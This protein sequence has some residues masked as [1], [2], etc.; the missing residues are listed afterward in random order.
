MAILEIVMVPDPVLRAK[1]KKVSKVT[2]AIQKLLD[3]MTDTMREAP[4]I[5]LAAPQ[6]GAL[7]RLIVVEVLNDEEYPDM[8]V[9]FYQ[10]VN[11]EIVRISK[12]VEEG[13]EGCLS[14][15]GYTADVE[16]FVAVEV[17]ALDRSGKPVK[18]KAHGFLA[19]VLQHEIDHLD[20]VLYLDRLTGPD[21]LHKIPDTEDMHAETDMVG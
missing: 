9:G 3:D 5:G 18:I 21:K 16:R 12:D 20:G 1:A 8:Q 17:R 7:Q 2:P 14:I 10:L 6:V 11:P 19:R 4:G 15:P 13:L